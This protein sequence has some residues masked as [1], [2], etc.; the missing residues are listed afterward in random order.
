MI[1]KSK[2]SDM[3][4]NGWWD[5]LPIQSHKWIR[6]ARFDRPI[7]SWLL[8][9]PCL[10][11][12]PLSNLN[13]TK[14]ISLLFLFTM[15]AF[16]MRSSGCIINDLW[17]K[18]ID[19]NISRTKDRPLASGQISTFKAF[20]FLGILLSLALL[21]LLNLN[22]QTWIIAFLSMPLIVIYPLAKRFT[23]WPQI[24]LGFA[25][26]WGVPTAWVSTG[27]SLNLGIIF[28]YIGTVF[29]VIGYDTIYGCQDRSEDK[30]FGIKNSSISAEN[31]LSNFIKLNYLTSILCFLFGGFFLQLHLG[32]FIGVFIMFIHLY[33]QTTEIK[34]LNRDLSLK[35]F[36]SNKIAGLFLVIGSFSKFLNF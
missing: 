12:L 3:P 7:G 17:D 32:W 4:K 31:Y 11:T 10:W 15:G 26:S 28:I 29:W 25:F 6:L 1:M 16:L 14:V 19:K 18:N 20:L 30:I 21:C 5:Y 24:V 9:L 35:I 23:R 33:F 8:L 13:I 2:N 22:K 27:E 34:K 36:N